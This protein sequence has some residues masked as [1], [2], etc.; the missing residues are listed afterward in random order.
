MARQSPALL[1]ARFLRTE[2][3]YILLVLFVV[4]VHVV[5]GVQYARAE[6][7]ENRPDVLAPAP[8]SGYGLGQNT[9]LKLLRQA[10]LSSVAEWKRKDNRA[11]LFPL[12]VQRL[13]IV[14][15]ITGATLALLLAITGFIN[16]RYPK[17]EIFV[18]PAWNLWDCF[19]AAACW[20]AGGLLFGLIF[21]INSPVPNFTTSSAVALIFVAVFVIGIVIHIG[22]SERGMRPRDLGLHLHRIGQALL[23]AVVAFL[24]L[25]P[26]LW[27]I[28][29]AQF[30]L[31]KEL[32]VHNA[33][34]TLLRSRSLAVITL[35]IVGTVLAA[36]IAEEIFFRG[37]LQPVLQKWFGPW[38]GLFLCA[39][40]FA[41]V[42]KHVYVIAP[43]FV[44][45]IALGYI[46]NRTRSLAAP[47][48]LHVLS[49]GLAILTVMSYR[50]IFN[51]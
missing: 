44:L 40:F 41:L 3:F 17:V 14:L 16:M 18:R 15:M 19:K 35:T 36:P 42:H 2:A 39:A 6:M 28:E 11:A 9:D 8:P 49:N 26:I 25:Q 37:M 30:E 20:S 10:C 7:A 45:G 32:P 12:W 38:S 27:M 4:F 21:G 31:F 47:I 43:L 50:H 29:A 22:V 24:V 48:M 23:V 46:Y 33:I 34:E 5:Q 13:Q 1:A 51:R